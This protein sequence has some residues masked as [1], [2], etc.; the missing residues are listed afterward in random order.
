MPVFSYFYILIL[1]NCFIGGHLLNCGKLLLL[2]YNGLIFLSFKI[3][4]IFLFLCY[5]FLRKI[6]FLFFNIIFCKSIYFVDLV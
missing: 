4:R 2:K 6:N 5:S 1:S 3:G